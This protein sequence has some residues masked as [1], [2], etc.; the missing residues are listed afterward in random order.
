MNQ[1]NIILAIAFRDFKKFTQDR[2]RILATFIFP[3][4]FIGILGSSLQS[5]LSNQVGFNF[6]TFVF[7]GVFAQT[8]FQSTSSGI[9]SLIQDRENDFSQ[10][11]FVSPISRYAI[12]IGKIIG[13]SLVALIQVIG[14][15]IFGVILGAS[16]SFNQLLILLPASI[17]VCLLG[18]AFGVL[19]LANLSNQQAANQIFP[20]LIFPQFF[21]AGIFSPIQ[22]LPIYL[23][24][25]S[26]ISPMTYA[27]D[28]V[29]ALYYRGQPEYSKIVLMN[30]WL[31]LLII[32][33]MFTVFIL[34]G[35][36]LFV[37]NER[38]R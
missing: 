30:P 15:V 29:R 2:G 33:L 16:L 7:T 28:F 9:I 25:L 13:E 4:L 21:L 14:V 23:F 34:L 10:E 35:T 20:F 12:V 31:D 1:L 36:F 11:M 19:V 5:N 6:L 22:N 24:I 32:S 18:G 3:V 8:L 17:I 37:R 26:R 27:V 38:N